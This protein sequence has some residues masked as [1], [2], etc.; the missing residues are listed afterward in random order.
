[1]FSKLLEHKLEILGGTA[2]IA[3]IAGYF[4]YKR[5]KKE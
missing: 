1:M 4:F 3:G 5:S 2:I